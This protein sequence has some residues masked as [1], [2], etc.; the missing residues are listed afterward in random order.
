MKHLVT[1]LKLIFMP[2]ETKVGVK[3]RV[4]KKLCKMKKN[5]ETSDFCGWAV[6]FEPNQVHHFDLFMKFSAFCSFS[7]DVTS[8]VVPKFMYK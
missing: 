1:V 3:G 4:R 5:P 7:L 6:N 8:L 2:R